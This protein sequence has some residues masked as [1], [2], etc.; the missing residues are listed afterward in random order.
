MLKTRR[1]LRSLFVLGIQDIIVNPCAL[2][3][4]MTVNAFEL[5]T[6]LIVCWTSYRDLKS[7]FHLQAFLVSARRE[8]KGK[9][10]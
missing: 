1:G 7:I 4:D 5:R 3:L 9:R 8:G 6:V 10:L 2:V